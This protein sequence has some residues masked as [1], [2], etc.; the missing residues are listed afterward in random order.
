MDS[1]NSGTALDNATKESSM[2]GAGQEG[3][4]TKR[5]GMLLRYENETD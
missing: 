4:C 5:V 3:A 2:R 1:G